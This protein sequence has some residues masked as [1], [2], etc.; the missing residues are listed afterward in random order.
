M[1][2]SSLRTFEIFGCFNVSAAGIK[3]LGQ[4]CPHLQTLNL[5]QCYKVSSEVFFAVFALCFV[6]M[7]GSWFCRFLKRT[8]RSTSLYE[9]KAYLLESDIAELACINK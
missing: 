8:A 9:K 7:T 2:S 1:F 4:K 5:G 3:R 6:A